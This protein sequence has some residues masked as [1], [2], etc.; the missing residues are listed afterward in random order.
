MAGTGT[1]LRGLPGRRPLC[2]CTSTA[3][4]VATRAAL[5]GV[6]LAVRAAWKMIGLLGPSGAGK[7]TL[8]SLLAGVFRP[9]AGTVFV[10]DLDLTSATARE[11]DSCCTPARCRSCCR[12][13]AATCC[14]T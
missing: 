7:S 3:A 9:T 6:D 12:A 13:R 2:W 10:G 5:S 1:G 4:R 14:P 8:L 11:L